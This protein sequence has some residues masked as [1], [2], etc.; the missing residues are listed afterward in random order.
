MLKVYI[1]QK[2]STCREALK[3]LD[4]HG[5]KHEVKAIRET[6]PTVSELKVALAAA[7]GDLRKIFNTSGMD[8]R[9]MG[10]KGRLPSISENEALEM[11][12]R[13]GNLVKRPFVIGNGIAL[14]GFKKPEWE[15]A[16]SK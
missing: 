14:V 6:P 13:H 12:S 5:I 9:A 11:L 10:L 1:Y 16:L 4:A 7:N 3:W 8:Y 15:S 2:C